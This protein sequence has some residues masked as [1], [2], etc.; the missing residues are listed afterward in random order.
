MNNFGIYCIISHPVLSHTSIAEICVKENI[1]FI[2]LRE[3]DMNDK[4]LLGIAKELKSIVKGSQTHLVMNDR[5]DIAVLCEADVL[6][7]GQD[8]MP[9]MEAKKIVKENTMIGL[10]THNLSQAQEAMKYNPL[11]IGFGPIYPTT[12]KAHP[13]PVV[14]VKKLREVLTFASVPVVAIGGIFPENIDEVLKTGA[15][16]LCMVR[17]LMES[18]TKEELTNK[19]RWIKNKITCYDTNG[20]GC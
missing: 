1:R 15:K 6:H 13:D 2:Q 10:S 16:N 12:T 20:T 7:L 18:S 9:I 19:L 3:K 5:P 11:Y 14:G 4:K 17:Y 8:D